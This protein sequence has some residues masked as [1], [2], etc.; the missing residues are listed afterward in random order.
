MVSLEPASGNGIVSENTSSRLINIPPL[1]GISPEVDRGGS[2]GYNTIRFNDFRKVH[3]TN[4]RCV[5]MSDDERVTS[6]QS[7]KAKTFGRSL[8]QARHNHFVIDEPEFAGGPGEAVTPEESFLS[9]VASCGVMLMDKFARESGIPLEDITVDVR[10]VRD[11]DDPS[12]YKRVE[13]SVSLDGPDREQ[14]EQLL[15]KFENR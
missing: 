8:N 10:G 3:L 1:S 4:F 9:G 14:A 2:G 13:M 11:T 12:S 15:E 6:V 7:T 5:P